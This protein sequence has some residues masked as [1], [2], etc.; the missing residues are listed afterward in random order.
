MP[1]VD[2]YLLVA[3]G[4]G[5]LF[6]RRPTAAR[7]AATRRSCSLLMAA[8]YGVRG[9]GAP[10]GARGRA[11][12]CSARRCRRRAIRRRVA[13][14]LV[15]SLAARRRRRHARSRA[16]A[17]SSRSPRCRRSSRRSSGGRSRRLSNAYE[18]HDIDLL[19]RAFRSRTPIRA[20]WRVTLRYPNIW[21]PP[22]TAGGGDTARPGVPRLLALSRRASVVDRPARRPCA[23]T[24]CGSPA[25]SSACDQ[26]TARAIRSP[27]GAHRRRRHASIE[28]A[29]RLRSMPRLGAHMSVAGGLPR[30]V[31]RAVV[32]R[33]E[34]LQIFAKNASQWRGRVLPR[35]GDPRVPRAGDSRADI[36][37][38]VSHAQ[39]SDQP[40]DRPTGAAARSRWR[41]WA[42]SSIAPKR[43]GCS[44]SSCI[45][46]ATRPAA[47]PTA[48]S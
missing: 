44:A 36:G 26:P 18:M 17:V 11:A 34:A 19:D 41:R 24:T 12:R 32:H 47:K 33:C 31:E 21:T 7:R 16:S 46:A 15:D 30:A 1:I 13:T 42:T 4:V 45:R 9:V 22:V 2:I 28:R 5:L 48:S 3:L 27:H 40:R 20:P 23:G 8:N 38:V 35:R 6:G 14:A 43:S 39:L 29:A 37:P 25:A 10:S